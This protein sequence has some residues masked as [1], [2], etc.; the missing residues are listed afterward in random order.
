MKCPKCQFENREGVDFC[1]E[2]GA[3]LELECPNCK[4][5]IPF[6][7]KFC[8]KCGYALSEST[9]TAYLEKSEHN[10]Q[11]PESPPEETVITE[12]KAEG[13]RKFV[14]VLFSDLTGY[15]ALSEKLD[16]E[17]VKE[18]TSRIFGE[19][20]KI[21][22]DY[23]GFIEKY[24]GDAVMALFG[25]TAS[26]EDDPVRAINTAREIHKLVDSINPRYEEKIGQSLSMHSG[27]NTGLVVT[28][29]IN[30]EKGT[31]GVAGDTVNVAARLSM[32]GR[33]GEIVV[34][35]DTYLQS[36]GYFDFEDIGHSK[37]K[38][39]DQP[40]RIYRVLGPKVQPVKVHRLH[41]L[42][43]ELIGRKME[44][45]VLTETVQSLQDGKG[46]ILSICGTAGTGKSRLI[47]EFRSTLNLEEVQWIEGHAYPYT[48]NIPYYLLINLLSRALLIE[49]GDAPDKIKEKVETGL[50]N[51]I[52]EDSEFIPYIGSLYALSYPEIDN[53]DPEYWKSQI[54][55][56]IQ[57]ILS[58]V[59]KQGPTV[60]CLEDLHWADP[61]F[62]ELI[63]LILADFR[64]PIFFLCIY[65]PVITLFTSHQINAMANPYKEILLQDLSPSESHE[66]VESLLRTDQVPSELK[67]FVQDKVEGNPFYVEE[68]INSL[69]ESETLLNDSDVW[70][71]T[72]PITESEISPTIHGVIAGRLDRLEKET[73]K[74]LQEASVIGRAFLYEILKRITQLQEHID[75]SL[76]GLERLDLLRTRSVQP[77]LEYIFK[78]ALT[79]EVVYNG[80]LKSERRVIHERIGLVMEQLFK[81]RLPEFYET[82]SFHFSQARSLHK[83]VDYLIKSGVKSLKRYA[84]EESHQYYQQA[85]NLLTEK[86]SKTEEDRE[87]LFDLLIKWSLVYYYRGDFKEHTEL[88]KRHENEADLVNDKEKRGMFYGWIGFVLQFRMELEDSFRYLNKALKLGEEIESEYLI[89][90]ACTWLTY[91]CAV[92]DQYEEGYS[93]WKRAVSIAKSIASDPYL[94][95]KSIAGIGHI[96]AF[97]GEKKHSYDIGSQ[98]LEYGKKNSNIR[99]QVLGHICMGHSYFAEGNLTKAISCYR[100]AIEVAEDPFYTQWPRLYLGLC[101]VLDDQ[102][103]EGEKAL[104]EVSSYVN[105]FGAELFAPAINPFIGIILIKKGDMSKGLKIIEDIYRVS[106]EKN[107]GYAIALSEF[108]LANLYYQ[109]AHGEKPS[110]SILLKNT[111]FLAKNVPFAS[112]KAE[113]YFNKAIE[114]AKQYGSKG[115]QAMAYLGLGLL[116]KAKKRKVQAKKCFSDA[117]KIFEECGAKVYLEQAKEALESLE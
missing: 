115:F 114:N 85:Y 55:K 89:G 1:E 56:A 49:E 83:A 22:A 2:C 77:D 63:R 93:Y 82:L 91:S 106:K 29:E 102:I 70:K 28:G 112:K 110:M 51:L 7:R 54:Q 111:G 39:K 86:S 117:I 21:V 12:I 58:S 13:E 113:G 76:N 24:A 57:T 31:H 37:I 71:I 98:L 104:N 96:E 94:Y 78:H 75:K 62:L 27:I 61:S 26:H 65:R 42:K 99:S 68:M 109:L 105:K 46:S 100:K 79:Q 107:W 67:R 101:C 20:S 17:E 80:L 11:I 38:G 73:K 103:V 116:H 34:S 41:G 64:E 15:T 8:G 44:M 14:T 69:I 6:G 45:D 5:K 81:D 4:A 25:A 84:V 36:E 88:L 19:I 43:S 50:S 95:F 23:D 52:G 33:A 74:I 60:I 72:R 59:A 48:Q 108:V 32:L 53:I 47:E 18:I 35:R 90:Y 92:T 10:T 3:K 87:L 40:V 9:E 16:P 30:F 97:N 66:M